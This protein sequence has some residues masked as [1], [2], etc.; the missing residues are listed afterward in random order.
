[1]AFSKFKNLP[2]VST[3]RELK[4]GIFGGVKKI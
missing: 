2:A 3:Q 1:M 4:D